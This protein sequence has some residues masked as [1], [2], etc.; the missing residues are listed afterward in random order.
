MGRMGMAKV[1]IEVSEGLAA[2]LL[3]AELEEQARAAK[4]FAPWMSEGRKRL[5]G[6]RRRRCG[7][8][9]S[10]GGF[11]ASKPKR[12]TSSLGGSGARRSG[13]TRRRSGRSKGR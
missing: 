5:S 10:E 13:G 6:T 12:S 9:C 7:G 2:V 8:T 4:E 1:T 3:A 11:R